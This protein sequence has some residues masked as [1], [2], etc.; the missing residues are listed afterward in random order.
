MHTRNISKEEREWYGIFEYVIFWHKHSRITTL[1]CTRK[2]ILV[3]IWQ[4]RTNW[5]GHCSIYLSF[6]QVLLDEFVCSYVIF[7]YAFTPN[8]KQLFYIYKK[9]PTAIL[10]LTA[11]PLYC[12]FNAIDHILKLIFT[13]LL[14]KITSY[15]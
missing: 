9:L 12:F 8:M 10:R 13:K 11:K 5:V 6:W 1:L 14:L 4:H 2:T 3:T 7:S 15:K